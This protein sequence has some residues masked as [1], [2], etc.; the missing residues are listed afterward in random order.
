MFA[1]LE[2]PSLTLSIALQGKHYAFFVQMRKLGHGEA[3]KLVQVQR[4]VVRPVFQTNF[5]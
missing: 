2:T 4:A 3:K 5:A 1:V